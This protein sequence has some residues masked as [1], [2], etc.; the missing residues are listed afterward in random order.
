[1]AVP[2]RPSFNAPTHIIV[3]SLIGTTIEYFDFYIYGTAAVLVFPRLFFPASDP[4]T[5]IVASLATFGVAF[6]ARPVGSILF[7]HFGDRF[8]RKSTLVVA[9]L[10]M[11]VSTVVIG[12]L[13]TYASVGFAAPVVLVVCRFGQGLGLGGEWGGATLVAIE[14]APPAHRA[15]YGMF[16]QLGAPVGLLLSGS[17]FLVLSRFTTPVQFIAFAWRL[18]FV[19]SAVL[20]GLG[21]YV[22]TTIT[23]APVFS[24]ARVRGETVRFPVRVLLRD[25]ARALVYGIAIGLSGFVTFYMLTVFALSWATSR[26]GFTR[27]SFLLIQLF[28]S[29]SFAL[30]IL[31]GASI[32][33]RGR[34]GMLIGANAAMIVFALFWPRLLAA[35]TLPAALATC[36][37]MWI[38]G[39]VF[40][41]LGTELTELFPVNVRYSGT[42]LAFSGTGIVGASLA[43]YAATFLATRF[44]LQS[45][46]Y[47][48]AAAA[49]VSMWAIA[50]RRTASR[51]VC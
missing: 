35:G 20:V 2:P 4:A 36:V 29:G 27:D 32:S 33:E 48:M 49:A 1:M 41:P 3:A 42:S 21:L 34:R 6:V 17:V 10:T 43:P 46:G 12:A 5:A 7:G 38:V 51:R 26:L 30:A 40:G 50:A 15:W 22:R 18:P 28:G 39:L 24:A 14:N 31:A 8:G 37:G 47:Y 45:V 19:A 25:H 9:L 23:E 13:P 44:G 16:P 11:G